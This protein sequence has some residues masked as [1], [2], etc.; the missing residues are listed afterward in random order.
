MIPRLLIPTVLLPFTYGRRA[1]RA[2]SKVVSLR[3]WQSNLPNSLS[4]L[5]IVGAPIFLWLLLAEAGHYR[6]WA[7]FV[8]GAACLTDLA[9]GYLARRMGGGSLVGR[10]LDPLADKI[11]VAAALLGFVHLGLVSIWPVAVMMARDVSVTGLRMKALLDGREIMTSRFA[12][13]KTAVQLI[14][15]SGLSVV[16]SVS[17]GARAGQVPWVW[18]TANAFVSVTALLA[19]VAGALYFVRWARRGS[20]SEADQD[21]VVR[22]DGIAGDDVE[23]ARAA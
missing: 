7:P 8:F 9:D 2:S 23:R 22:L 6:A 17:E 21:K 10:F 15:V 19:V 3:F 13:W 16:C 5:R 18:W 12:K 1:V 14:V 20:A 11:L 4:I